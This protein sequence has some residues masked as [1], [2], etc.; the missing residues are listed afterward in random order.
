[1]AMTCA[2]C[3]AQNPDGNLYCQTCGTPLAPAAPM[4]AAPPPASPAGFA[5]P[6]AGFAPPPLGMPP[7]APGPAGYQSPY[8]APAAP[9]VAV[10]RTPWMLI[11]AAVVA[12]VVLMA[13]CGTALA[14]LGSRGSS[15]PAQ[16]QSFSTDVPSPSPGQTPSPLPTPS[17]TPASTSSTE[18]NDGVSLTLPTG[19]SVADKDSESITLTDPNSSGSLTVASGQSSPT[20]TAQDNRNTID[21]YFKQQYPDS[22]LCPG[23]RAASSTFNGARGVSWQL[24][25]TITSGGQSIPA[26]A[27]LFAGANQ[28][29]SVYY[30]VML[31]TRQENLATFVRD[32]RPVLQSVHWKLS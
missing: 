28:T 10:H 21:T 16:A 7:P 5:A 32:S 27:S 1:M 11:V 3:G 30:V 13:G 29:G 15:N 31:I 22:R 19:W 25:F 2:R 14:V 9:G 26:A 12:L 17:P 8:Y 23:A 24:C 4:A 6:P 18:S 20:Q